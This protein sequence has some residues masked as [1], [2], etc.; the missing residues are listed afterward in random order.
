MQKPQ[1]V[2]PDEVCR[3][4]LQAKMEVYRAKESFESALKVYNDQV[5]NL[6]NLT[7]LMKSRILEMEGELKQ[8]RTNPEKKEESNIAQGV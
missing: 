1:T 2:S 3:Q 7:G 5:D 6:I 8:E 4:A